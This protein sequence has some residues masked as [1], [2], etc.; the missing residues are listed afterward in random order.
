MFDEET[1]V[2]V[3]KQR[4]RQER[5][6]ERRGVLTRHEFPELNELRVT[7]KD[8][9]QQFS[10]HDIVVTTAGRTRLAR[11]CL[12]SIR[13]ETY[14]NNNVLFPPQLTGEMTHFETLSLEETQYCIICFYDGTNSGALTR[15]L[16]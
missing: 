14:Y 1:R 9:E 10:T 6:R 8:P 3:R 2:D 13:Y 4:R 12:R 15:W 11:S 16:Q 7:C 5:E